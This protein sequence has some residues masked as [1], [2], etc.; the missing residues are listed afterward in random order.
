MIFR[1]DARNLNDEDFYAEIEYI[2]AKLKIVL[3]FNYNMIILL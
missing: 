1:G 3:I 2:Q